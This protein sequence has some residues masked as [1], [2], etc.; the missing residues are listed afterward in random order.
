MVFNSPRNKLKAK[1]TYNNQGIKINVRKKKKRKTKYPC[2]ECSN[3]VRLDAIFCEYCNKWY[4]RTCVPE[5][6]K[7]DLLTLAKHYPNTWTCYTCLNEIFPLGLIS[8]KPDISSD[9][10]KSPTKNTKK[11]TKTHSVNINPYPKLLFGDTELERVTNIKFLGVILS[12]TFTWT[13]HLNYITS[14]INKN[15]G[16]FYK[17]RR[18]LDHKE[19]INLYHSFIE[20]YITYCIPVWGGYVNLESTT[21]PVINILNKLTI[22]THHCGF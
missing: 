10:P 20:P 8:T 21:N 18:I 2:G 6:K 1:D 19:L 13:D 3:N 5:L 22:V 11:L 4:H 7:N 15:I 14:K 16:F 12:E 17:A 9:T